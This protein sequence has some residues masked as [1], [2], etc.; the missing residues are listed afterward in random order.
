MNEKKIRNTK[1]EKQR[2]HLKIKDFQDV[3]F[4][5]SVYVAP[6]FKTQQNATFPYNT[7]RETEKKRARTT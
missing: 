1:K 7:P 6:S 3:C 4:P 2:K 5:F